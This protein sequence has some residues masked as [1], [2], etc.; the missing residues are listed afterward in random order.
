M[1]DKYVGDCVE[2]TAKSGGT[3]L[4]PCI[5]GKTSDGF[6]TFDELYEHRC[7]LFLAFLRHHSPKD[8]QWKSRKHHDG[9]QFPGWFMVG[10]DLSGLQISYHLPESMWDLAWF[11]PEYDCAPRDWDG[12]SP[13]DVCDRLRRWILDSPPR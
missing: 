4:V 11:L 10:T 6:H 9:S 8:I 2:V 3:S 13:Q 12:H 1:D 7:L 5:P